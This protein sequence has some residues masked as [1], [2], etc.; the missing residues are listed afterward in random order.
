M[1][2]ELLRK[3]LLS[4]RIVLHLFMMMFSMYWPKYARI[5]EFPIHINHLPA[6][7]TWQQAILVDLP[8]PQMSFSITCIAKPVHYRSHTENQTSVAAV[9][10][11]EKWFYPTLYNG[12]NYSLVEDPMVIV[13]T[14]TKG[15]L[16][17][18]FFHGMIP[19]RT[20]GFCFSLLKLEISLA[21]DKT[22]WALIASLA[23]FE[24][25]TLI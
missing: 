11:F 6:F 16:C 23:D 25:S 2:H 3:C 5:I 22:T 12:C 7:R 15:Q 21:I 10:K 9:L 18:M 1:L 19:S 14:H 8:I 24:K 17:S 13:H 4:A 20:R